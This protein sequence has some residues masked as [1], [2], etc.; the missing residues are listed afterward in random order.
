MIVPSTTLHDLTEQMR[1]Y[2]TALGHRVPDCFPIVR[3][4]YVGANHKTALDECRAALQ[5][6]YDAYASWGLSGRQ[7][8]AFEELVR[9]RFIIGDTAFVKEEILRYREAL[10]VDHF[11]MRCHW[12]G[13]EFDK[14]IAS[15]RRLGEIFA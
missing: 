10:G 5:Y 6:K 8:P 11:M 15:I 2:R 4:C 13:L 9:N 14:S 12:P 1:V 7:T 3:E